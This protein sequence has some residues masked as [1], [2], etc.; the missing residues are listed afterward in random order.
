MTSTTVSDSIGTKTS[1]GREDDL[2]NAMSHSRLLMFFAA[3]STLLLAELPV[4]S[5]EPVVFWA[6]QPVLPGDVVLLYGG[7]LNGVRSVSIIRLADGPAGQPSPAHLL[8]SAAKAIDVPTLQPTVASLKFILPKALPPG[9]FAVGYGGNPILIGA[10]QVEW[11][12]PTKLL[13]GLTE[14]EAAPG[15]TIQIIGRNFLLT[16]QSARSVR[17]A[18]RSK[19]GQV[20]PLAVLRPDKY[21][22]TARLPASLA[23][24]PYQIWIHNGYGGPNG[25][26][27]GL[28][29]SIKAPAIWPSTV[30]N[31]KDFGARGDNISDDSGSFHSALGA[32]QRN[33]GGVVYFPAG[34]YRLNGWFFI[35][36][37]VVLSGEARGVTFLKW[38]ETLPASTAGF[39]PAVLYSAGEVEI[40]NLTLVAM[41]TQTI[42]RDLSWDASQS[43]KVPV[44][45][46]Q[47]YISQP[48]TERDVF[49]RN[50]DFQLLYYAPRPAKPAADPRWALNGFGWKNNE[51]VKVIAIDGIRNVEISGC[52]FVGG[53]QRVLDAV[54][55]RLSDNRF[56]NQWATLSWTD[57]GG[58]YITFQNN[59]LSGASGWR[60]GLLVVRHIYCAYNR[61][62]NIVSGE[63]EALAFDVNEVA[64][65]RVPEEWRSLKLPVVKP[66][67]GYIASDKGATA[68]LADAHLPPHAYHGLDLLVLSGRGA[69]QY[70]RINDN[71][72]D[73]ITGSAPWAIEPNQ[74]SLVIAFQLPGRCIFYGNQAQDTSA[75]F[76]IWGYLYDCTF[77]S[78]NVARTQGMWGLS[79]WFIQWLGNA[80]RVAATY[81][82]GVGPAGNA[83]ETTPEGGAPYGLLGFVIT[84]RFASQPIPF[85][86][87]RA[88]VIRANHLSFGHRVLVMFGYGG[89]QKRIRN[90]AARDV[91]ID[92]NVIDHSRVGVELDANVAGA[93][94]HD[95]RF[96]DVAAPLRIA[97]PARALVLERK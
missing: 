49:L 14:N 52:R 35:P 67:L 33:G 76:E 88:C 93:L 11:C 90:V 30:F 10:P 1:S 89:A 50:V 61:S 41:S 4:A 45:E 60:A 17:V 77:D 6:S 64:G 56:D 26:G 36:K 87:V 43:G 32:A 81:H 92:R 42:L 19:G 25:W 73:S 96:T 22:V 16:P 59:V 80:L 44:S 24:G 37:R 3:L 71:N 97:D 47:P 2:C 7:D 78:N 48:G 55:A 70:Q 28:T 27:G 15:S 54:N 31:V 8:F 12:Q 21:S 40:E 39:I 34:T 86:S 66:W 79:G 62:E 82:R 74:T 9:V 13:P 75:P 18:L 84:G 29:L 65:R 46:L 69:G 57:L 5:A 85:P 91:I 58:Q 83:P 53:T 23:A 38:P 68:R 63:R 95:N 72:E 94:L 51:R 20:V